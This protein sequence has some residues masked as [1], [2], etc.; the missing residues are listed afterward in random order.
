MPC[1]LFSGVTFILFRFVF[2]FLL[3]LKPRPFV[4]S[5]F[6]LRYACVPTATRVFPF[7]F[8]FFFGAVGFFCIFVP[9]PFYLCV[10]S[11]SYIFPFRVVFSAHD[12]GL[13]FD[14]SLCENSTNS[15]R[16]NAQIEK[17]K[18]KK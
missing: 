15:A 10:G 16:I 18:K 6:V 11:A 14:I 3:S 2:V 9:L 5:F 8:V 13:D 12:Q 1:R 7:S 4:Q 17:K